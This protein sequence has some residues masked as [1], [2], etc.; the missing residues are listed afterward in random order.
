MLEVLVASAHALC[1][2]SVGTWLVSGHH[3]ARRLTARLVGR[4]ACCTCSK[5]ARV[6]PART[7]APAPLNR[8]GGGRAEARRVLTSM[9]AR[10]G[11]GCSPRAVSLALLG[12]LT[13]LRRIA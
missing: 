4:L 3:L 6:T 12:S 13:A 10:H 9:L 8:D 11:A 5:R 1:G 2:Q 7:A